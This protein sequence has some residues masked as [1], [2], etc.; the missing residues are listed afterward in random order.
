MEPL[1][2]VCRLRGCGSLSRILSC[3]VDSPRG[4]KLVGCGEDDVVDEAGD[5][6]KLPLPAPGIASVSCRFIVACEGAL[7]LQIFRQG[8]VLE[9]NVLH[10]P[11]VR[12]LVGCAAARGDGPGGTRGGGGVSSRGVVVDVDVWQRRTGACAVQ[13]TRACVCACVYVCACV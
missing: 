11:H 3:S 13:C 10:L 4:A 2:D 12:R 9:D 1:R 5:G 8:R 6:G 7:T